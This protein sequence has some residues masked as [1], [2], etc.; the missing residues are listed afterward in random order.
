M[1]R[2]LHDA[3]ER[4]RADVRDHLHLGLDHLPYRVGRRADLLEDLR[5][6]LSDPDDEQI[7]MLDAWAF[8][9]DVTDFYQQI[10]INEQYMRTATDSRSLVELGRLVGSRPSPGVSAST[11]LSLTVAD[12]KSVVLDGVRAQSIPAPGELPQVYE[13]STRLVATSRLNTLALRRRTPPKIDGSTSSVEVRGASPPQ[14]GEPLVIAWEKTERRVFKILRVERIGD[15]SF[16][17]KVEA[18]EKKLG[19]TPSGGRP[20]AH[21]LR[22]RASLFGYNA[23]LCR[24]ADR[25]DTMVEPRLAPADME[26]NAI[27][28]DAV[29]DGIEVGSTVLVD[30]RPFTAADVMVRGRSAYGIHQK[31]TRILLAESRDPPNEDAF[32]LHRM[33]VVHAKAEA[34]EILDWAIAEPISG[35]RI[36]LERIDDAELLPGRMVIVADRANPDVAE[37]AIIA[38]VVAEPPA[39]LLTSALRNEFSRSGAVVFANV[40]LATHG[41]TQSGGDIALGSGDAGRRLQSFALP[42]G[43]L[44]HVLRP[45]GALEAALEV[46][47]D[48][49]RWERADPAREVS[50]GARV[51]TTTTDGGGR[52]FVV[53]GD[54]KTGGRI[55]SGE[56]NVRVRYRVGLGRVG[57]VGR[58]R[59][60]LLLERPLGLEAVTNPIAASGGA[61]PDVDAPERARVATA[62]AGLVQRVISTSDYALYARS[63]PGIEKAH[64]R[65]W[66]KDGRIGVDLAVASAS[67]IPDLTLVAL[68]A[69]LLRR[70][71]PDVRLRILRAATIKCRVHLQVVVALGSLWRDVQGR[72]RDRLGSTF[73][74]SRRQLAKPLY[75][76]EI[77]AEVLSLGGVVHAHVRSIDPLPPPRRAHVDEP[78]VIFIDA[79]EPTTLTLE[80]LVG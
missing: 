35:D 7:A 11:Y 15:R 37:T 32:P 59:I 19:P 57:N 25:P 21:V 16:R 27:H 10:L 9:A 71:D 30:G 14:P 1:I 72:I 38:S 17:L 76:S 18:W 33:I 43:P 73:A 52:M 68:R 78:S 22:A 53:F 29:Y 46:R 34:F 20:T 70:G 3:L 66:R 40:M 36:D 6:E 5:R 26:K 50:P 63:F 12:G 13:S 45:D 44:T 51:Y 62:R 56:E 49:V 61:D 67:A 39:I 42:R 69:D 80:E 47:V 23:P 60:T 8:V 55:P 77:V 75:P 54:G 31:T 2:R 48:D 65:P 41:E 74:F 58:D 28:L 64:A 4:R 24:D 79:D